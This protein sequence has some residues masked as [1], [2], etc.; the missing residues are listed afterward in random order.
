MHMVL[1]STLFEFHD[2]FLTNVIELQYV[3]AGCFSSTRFLICSI[4][5]VIKAYAISRNISVVPPGLM[6]LE[7]L[8]CFHKLSDL[9]TCSSKGRLFF[10]IQLML[11]EIY[12][13]FLKIFFL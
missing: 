5:V 1:P 7:L 3:S 10:Q 13:F 4:C 2:P 9:R 11:L 8:L 12:L 6:I